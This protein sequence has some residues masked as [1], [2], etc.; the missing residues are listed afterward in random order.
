M[1]ACV[2]L[3][4]KRLIIVVRL[5]SR[6]WFSIGNAS[7]RLDWGMRIL[8]SSFGHGGWRRKCREV[9]DGM[10]LTRQE[11]ER[12]CKNRKRKDGAK[13]NACFGDDNLTDWARDQ[14]VVR[15]MLVFR[16]KCWSER[17]E[18]AE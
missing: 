13:A 11:R 2:W 1:L 10:P 7:R 8:I 18:Q 17:P 5:S 16:P 15:D 3:I 6:Y 14:K 4:G 12:E 9:Y